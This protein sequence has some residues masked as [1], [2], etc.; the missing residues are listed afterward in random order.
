MSVFESEVSEILPSLQTKNLACHIFMML[1][2]H[3]R[4]LDWIQVLLA[5][6][7]HGGADGSK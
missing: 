5:S 6:E 2:E 1:K 7:T 4:L 3:M